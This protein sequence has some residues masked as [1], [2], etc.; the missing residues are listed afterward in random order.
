M[1]SSVAHWTKSNSSSTVESV[2]PGASSCS[3]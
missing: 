2:E 1:G 3:G